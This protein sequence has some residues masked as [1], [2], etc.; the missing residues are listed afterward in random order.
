[1]ISAHPFTLL[2]QLSILLHLYFQL[3][4]Q[5]IYFVIR[6]ALSDIELAR[7]HF[8]VFQDIFLLDNH[9]FG[10]EGPVSFHF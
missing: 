5:P 10:C 3:I 2:T 4:M 1:M 8:L 6:P 9:S 7:R